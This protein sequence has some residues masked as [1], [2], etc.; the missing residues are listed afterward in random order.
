[1]AAAFDGEFGARGDV[2]ATALSCAVPLWIDQ[3]RALSAEDRQRRGVELSRIISLGEKHDEIRGQHGAGPAL[4]AVGERARGNN[5]GG[6]AAVFNALAEGLALA[7]FQPGGVT[8]LG[9]HWEATH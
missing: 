1:M 6:P 8:Y 5:V 9:Q 3:V 7:A 2:L 4:F